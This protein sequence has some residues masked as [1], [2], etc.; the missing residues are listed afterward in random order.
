M[1]RATFSFR[2]LLR[3][4]AA[5]ILC[6][7]LLACKMTN[8]SKTVLPR[9]QDPP[10]FRPHIPTFQCESES[11][12]VRANDA[13]AEEWFLEAIALED[14]NN[15]ASDPDYKNIVRLTR[16]AAERR[17]WK[18]MLN[19]ASLYLEG[20]DPTHSVEDAVLLVEDAMRLGVPAAYDRIGTYYMNGTGVQRDLTKAYAFWQ[21]AAEMGNPQAMAYLASRLNV[22]PD[23]EGAS[24]WSNIPVATKMLECA[25]GQGYGQAAYDLY[26]LYQVP[27]AP[28]GKIIGDP[29][30]QTKARALNVLHHGV[31]LGCEDCANKLAIEFSRPF[32]L[33][34]MLVPYIDKAR[35]ARYT[36]LADALGFN[37]H[38]RFP[39]LDNV[40]PLPPADLPV[41]DGKR[42]T[43]LAA[44]M[45]VTPPPSVPKPSAAS[46]AIGR[47]FLD[48]Q[49]VLRATGETTGA[50]RAPAAGYWQ[51]ISH[52]QTGQTRA[53]LTTIPPGLYQPGEA[54]DRCYLAQGEGSMRLSDVVW[55][56]WETIRHNHGAVEPR[57]AR[58]LAREAPRPDLLRDGVTEPTCPVNGI[59]QPW[60]HCDHPLQSIVNQPWRQSWLNAGQAFPQPQRD[61]LLPLSEQDVTWYLMD[62]SGVDI[63]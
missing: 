50:T 8:E 15:Y 60:V 54:F 63:G 25:F 57:A 49:Y 31:R 42:E 36:M 11:S 40:L 12:K 5:A 2:L 38:R 18:A 52:Q 17:H 59:W 44:A 29:T 27:R 39:N 51:P 61:W 41:W 7:P 45:G 21:K 48:A 13:Q 1:H 32:D 55:E 23:N 20:R 47:P 62:E 56:R 26:F 9:D 28:N 37:P 43:L 22:G 24:Y 4:I 6:I 10:L 19:L 3:A 35:G 53:L 33:A 30:P 14:P 58:G 16:L 46:Q 34:K